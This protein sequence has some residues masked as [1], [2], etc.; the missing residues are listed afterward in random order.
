M[1]KKIFSILFLLSGLC[2]LMYQILWTRL[3]TFIIGN[4]YT[5]ISIIVASFMFGLFFG[6]WLIGRYMERIN[7]PVKWYA[8]LELSIGLYAAF[9]LLIFG[10]VSALFNFTHSIFQHIEPVNLFLKFIFTLLLLVIPTSAMGATLPL[11]VQ[12]FTKKR[13]SFGDNISLFYAVNTLG[14]AIG[15][16]IAGFFIIEYLGIREGILVTAVINILIGL[17]V[18]LYLGKPETTEPVKETSEKTEP[19]DK[20]AKKKKK[21]V[22]SGSEVALNYKTLLLITAGLSGFAALSF[23]ILWTR[24]LKFLILNSTYGFA[25][26]LFVFLLGIAIG[27]RIA[28][29]L[30]DKNNKLTYIYGVLQIALGIYSIFTIYLLYTFAYTESFQESIKKILYDYSYAWGW[31]ILAF[32]VTAILIYLIPTILMGV[33]YPLLNDLYYNKVS[34][35]AGKTVSSIYAINTIGAILGSLTAGFFL[36]PA[37]GIKSSIY[38]IAVINLLLG[39]IFIIKSKTYFRPVVLLSIPLLAV[40]IILSGS[41]KYLLGN[42]E[43]KT[44]DVLFYKEGLMATVKVYKRGNSKFLSIDGIPIASTSRSLMQ[45]EKLIA[46][47]PFFLK[48]NAEQVLAV[49]LASGI[50]AGS[51]TLHKD[52]KQLDC[53]ELIKPVFEA[54]KYFTDVNYDVF[55]NSKINMINDD[56]YSYLLY[57]DK[58]YDIISSDGKLGTLHSGNTIMLSA[59]YYE[60]CKKRLKPDGVFVQWIPIITPYEATKIIINTLTNS[61]KYVY[62]FYFYSSDILMAASDNPV[63]FDKAH[64]DS[65]FTDPVLNAE[66]Q[67]YNIFNSLTILSAY[68]GKY[69][70][71]DFNGTT[72]NSFNRPVLEFKYLRDWKKSREIPGGYRAKNMEFLTNHYANENP[73]DLF[74]MFKNVDKSILKNRLYMPTLT[75]LKFNTRN[76]ITGNYAL[77]FKRYIAFKKSLSF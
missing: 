45:K 7:N 53:V 24:G 46:H 73:D 9:L 49:G 23:E 1:N 57:T 18:M 39:L 72:I 63:V 71:S 34:K 70:K 67:K 37:F 59:D 35:K 32:I 3:F 74:D 44:D 77:G 61:F 25:S 65:L 12:Y 22:H 21:E 31:G 36:I 54:A 4:T 20:K 60:M 75:F 50:S 11:A 8:Y 43:K 30:S 52:L 29:R 56:I 33:L 66:F 76:F 51:M 10:M 64:M 26:I 68:V 16:L 19:V 28:K 38:I 15:V 47:L 6:S 13:K 27:G 17:T 55:N 5:A 69:D 62:L 42:K 14:G 40:A 58:K 41:G 48:P 2:G